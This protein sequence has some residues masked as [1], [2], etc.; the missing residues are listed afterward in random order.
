MIVLTVLLCA[1]AFAAML[2][3]VVLQV[4]DSWLIEVLYYFVAGLAWIVPA[5]AIIWWMQKPDD[6]GPKQTG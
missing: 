6:P 2:V 3:A 1:Y 4:N 5:G